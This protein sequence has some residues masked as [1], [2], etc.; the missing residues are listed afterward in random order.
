MNSNNNS[1]KKNENGAKKRVNRKPRKQVA[2][3]VAILI[4]VFVVLIATLVGFLWMYKPVYDDRPTFMTTDATGG[5][6]VIITDVQGDK[7]VPER[8]QEQ[9]NFLILGKDRWAFNTDVMIIASYNVTDG[10]ISMMQI[11][12]DTYIDVGRGN[13]K[14]NSLLASFYNE[15]LRT[16]EKDP[17]AAAIKGMEETFEKVFCI[18]ID[19]YAM[20]DLNGFVN[21]VDA[22]GGVEV[23]VPFDM[24]Y[25]DPIQ[26]L[27]INLKKGV[28]TLDGNK[29]EQ[30]IRFRADYVEGDIGRVDAQKIFISACLNKVKANFNV[31]TIAKIAEEVMKYVKTDIPLSDLLYY[32]KSALS[33]DLDKMTMLTLPGIQG[34]QYDTSGTWYYITYRDGT[35]AAVNKYFNSYNFAVTAEMFDKNDALYDSNGTYMHSVFLTEHKE[36]E[37][38]TAA[39]SDDI[40]IYKY[41][42]SSKPAVQT[43]AT[44]TTSVSEITDVTDGPA[45]TT[46]ESLASVTGT[47]I[48]TETQ[49]PDS[50]SETTGDPE[51]SET[52]EMTSVIEVPE[53]TTAP[54]EPV[55]TS[56][57]VEVTVSPETTVTPKETEAPVAETTAPAVVETTSEKE[58][59]AETEEE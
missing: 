16:G 46:A 6:D 32:A 47:D 22:L 1:S 56:G 53:D 18:T 43:T 11:P 49:D 19:Y 3:T 20:M 29:A 34:R 50:A 25:K 52:A 27:N 5:V 17:M 35:L 37:S 8:N 24:K 55:E 31:S 21:I 2:A 57:T 38:Y 36:E 39:N 51:L 33:V 26:N 40:Y 9:V 4:A 41:S 10:A 7:V 44:E 23:D 28:Q 54:E 45:V 12:R 15:A 13:H 42:S 14:A 48:H 58:T 30:F 59:S